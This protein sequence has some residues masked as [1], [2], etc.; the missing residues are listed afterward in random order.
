MDR[1]E[2]VGGEKMVISIIGEQT[3]GRARRSDMAVK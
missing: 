1:K 2:K 3:S